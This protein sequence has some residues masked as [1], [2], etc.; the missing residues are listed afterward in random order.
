[1]KIKRHSAI[2]M[3][4][5]WT[6]AGSGILLL[7]TGIG[8]LPLYKRYYFILQI[9]GLGWAGD[10]FIHL[11]LHYI[12]ATFFT[13]AVIFH[14]IYHG[15]LRHSSLLPKKGDIGRSVRVLLS[16]IGIGK[17]P[18]SEKYLPEQRIAYAGMGFLILLL[19]FSGVIKLVKN[20]PT[21]YISPMFNAVNTLV[22]TLSAFLFLL[23]LIV[24]LAVFVF[25]VNW[26][27]LKSMFTGRID[28]SYVRKR[29]GLWYEEVNKKNREDL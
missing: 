17:E 16:M 5:H 14:A 4:E 19:T 1:M 23:A 3:I 7:F 20:I 24:H 28:M 9:P 26:P 29:H 8:E 21:L 15:M 18:P 10:Y 25:P 27:L 13:A 11:K 6:I 22:H 12:F 2:E